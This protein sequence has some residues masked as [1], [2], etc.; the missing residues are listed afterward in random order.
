LADHDRP[1]ANDQDLLNV[2]S[3]RHVPSFALNYEP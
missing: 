3:L 1:C 2:S